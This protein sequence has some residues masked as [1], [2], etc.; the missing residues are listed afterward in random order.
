[1]P[2]QECARGV[3]VCVCVF[4]AVVIVIVV[5]IVVAI[6]VVIVVVSSS[7]AMNGST[8]YAWYEGGGGG[9]FLT[10]HANGVCVWGGGGG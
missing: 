10:K 3:C 9:T 1:M 5:A 4:L 6:V 8:V 7:K 2:S